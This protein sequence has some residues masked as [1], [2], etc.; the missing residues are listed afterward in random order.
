VRRFNADF[1]ERAAMFHGVLSADAERERRSPAE[2]V[3]L[4]E[5]Y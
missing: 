5:K 1:A 4:A 2:S 3:E